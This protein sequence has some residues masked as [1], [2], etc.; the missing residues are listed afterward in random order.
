[1]HAYSNYPTELVPLGSPYQALQDT[2]QNQSA[3][4]D[5]PN[6]VQGFAGVI[7]LSIYV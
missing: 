7:N 5:S 1:M 4:R 2:P 3:N 6:L